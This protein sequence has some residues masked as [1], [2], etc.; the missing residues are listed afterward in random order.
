MDSALRQPTVSGELASARPAPSGLPHTSFRTSWVSPLSNRLL[1]LLSVALVATPGLVQ[2]F[3]G[4]DDHDIG[5]LVYIAGRVLDG[6]RLYVELVEANPP[7]IVVLNMPA[8]LLSRVLGISDILAFELFVFALIAIT[9]WLS[10]R[11]LRRLVPASTDMVSRRLFLLLATFVLCAIPATSNVF[12]QR[13]HILLVLLL[14]Y[15]LAVAARATLIPLDPRTT[16]TVG[17]L[18]GVGVALK[19]Y[20]VIPWVL[21]E[22]YL[23]L[24]VGPKRA[25]LRPE[26][27][28]VVAVLVSYAIA[29]VVFTP[30]YFGLVM[31]LGAVYGDFLPTTYTSIL[32]D[33]RAL[34]VEH[35]L[36]VTWVTPSDN[37]TRELRKVL[38]LVTVGFMLATLLQHKGWEY[39]WYPPLAG[40]TLLLGVVLW[41]AVQSTK[42]KA[43]CLRI[44]FVIPVALLALMAAKSIRQVQHSVNPEP[45]APY[46]R[47][48]I[49]PMSR[50][51]RDEPKGVS[52][53]AFSSL[54]FPMFPAVNHTGARWA[55]R[56]NHFWALSGPYAAQARSGSAIRYHRP[57]QMTPAERLV[58]DGAISDMLRNTP[59]LL[60][61]L[62][63]P[64]GSLPH[65]KF[66]YITYFSQDPRFARLMQHY[67]VIARV[68]NYLVYKYVAG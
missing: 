22:I 5:W 33:W 43:L 27:I 55:I 3:F 11:V 44:G 48:L 35:A 25:W 51:I 60:F 58:Y 38:A 34:Y 41:D 63:P 61:V 67:K 20:F 9:L 21:A 64:N 68:G 29:V 40:A 12:A 14:P 42:A 30:D 36:I 6:A 28:A 37:R 47:D 54:P 62:M 31:I 10:A 49:A 45:G 7:L 53:A 32:T 66:N 39:H 2:V 24:R 50:I 59:R 52:I 8:A 18:A 19:P 26:N 65:P 17:V 16:I 56:F 46:M 1:F 15:L 57:D 13:E 4:T 23:A